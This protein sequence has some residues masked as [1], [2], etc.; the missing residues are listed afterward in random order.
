MRGVQGALFWCKSVATSTPF[1]AKRRTSSS[2]RKP[3]AAAG[4]GVRC[5]GSR[6]RPSAVISVRPDAPSGLL[7]YSFPLR[8][9]AAHEH[10]HQDRFFFSHPLP[11]CLQPSLLDRSYTLHQDHYSAPRIHDF[12]LSRTRVASPETFTVRVMYSFLTN[13]ARE[14]NEGGRKCATS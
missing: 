5:C 7:A 13:V 12:A 10:S 11:P 4:G 6:H 8:R 2:I 9:Q 14:L 3:D 1:T